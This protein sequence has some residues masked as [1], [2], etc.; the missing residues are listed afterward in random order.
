MGRFGSVDLRFEPV[1]Q[2]VGVVS[3]VVGVVFAR[4]PEFAANIQIT[5]AINVRHDRFVAAEGTVKNHALNQLGGFA[6]D[7]FPNEPT[8][9]IVAGNR[10]HFD[11]KDVEI[12]VQ[13][14]IRDGQRVIGAAGG[15][16]ASLELMYL[17]FAPLAVD[18]LQPGNFAGTDFVFGHDEV[19]L[20][21]AVHVHDDAS[22]AEGIWA[23]GFAE[24]NR[25][26]GPFKGFAVGI[27]EPGVGARDVEIAI[28]IDIANGNSSMNTG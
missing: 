25:M 22:C 27:L 17:P 18:V 9:L 2:E 20:A 10:F 23:G 5:V 28:P 6:I 3:A 13:V 11:G 19:A 24:R 14:E 1:L 4:T 16:I 21:V 8:R 7:I 15:V 12:A 26:F